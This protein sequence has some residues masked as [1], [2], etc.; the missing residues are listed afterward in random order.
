MVSSRHLGNTTEY[1]S[2]YQP[3]LLEAIPRHFGRDA[4]GL[5]SQTVLP[6][7]G[8][9]YWQAFEVSWLSLK[10]Q[11]QVASLSLQVPATTQAIVE[12]KSLKLYL[13]SLHFERFEHAE[14]YQRRVYED[15]MALLC[16]G[17]KVCPDQ[18]IEEEQTEGKLQIELALQAEFTPWALEPWQ[19]EKNVI[20]LDLLDVECQIYEPDSSLLGVDGNKSL[21]QTFFSHSFRSLCPVTGQPDFA[22][23]AV[24]YDGPALIVE[25]LLQYLVS[26]RN[27]QG[28]HEQ[29]IEGIFMD[30]QSLNPVSLSVIGRF[31]R[32]G[33]I[34]INPVR[35]TRDQT[36]RDWSSSWNRRQWRQ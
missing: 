22:S 6:F 18:K 26:F 12:S 21:Q 24:Y 33:G 28:F 32:R 10:G 20:N 35:S 5:K 30:L 29:C 7:I 34:D 17:Q 1:P 27:H 15:L 4:L 19:A 23:I 8:M 2:E 31:T 16:L 14:A 9:D 36:A 11:P 13:Q 25:S 3:D